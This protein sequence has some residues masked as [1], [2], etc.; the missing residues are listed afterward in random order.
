[1]PPVP[2]IDPDTGEVL[3]AAAPRPAHLVGPAVP[4]RR[5]PAAAPGLLAPGGGPARAVHP[6]TGPSP[7]RRVRRPGP[8]RRRGRVRPADP[9]QG[10]RPPDGPRREPG[11]RLHR[12]GAGRPGIRRHR[13]RAAGR[14]RPEDVRLLGRGDR[15]AAGAADRRLHLL[16]A[17]AG[18]RRRSRSTTTTPCRPA[19]CSSW[20]GSTPPGARSARRCG[21]WPPT[22]TTGSGWWRSP[23]CCR[24]RWRSSSGS[25]RR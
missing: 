6:G 19:T 9:A 1:M 14:H 10:D 16:A 13:P 4:R 25:T 22:P 7:D 8:V 18:P 15:Q 11:R 2:L 24:R 3:R 23:S 12:V 17:R 5:P 20:P 21:T